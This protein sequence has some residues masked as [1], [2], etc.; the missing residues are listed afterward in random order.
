[1]PS[2]YLYRRVS[3]DRQLDKAGIEIQVTEA[4]IRKLQ[5]AHPTFNI[6]D[7][8][9]DEG[10]S[11]YSGDH[12]KEGGRLGAFIELCMQGKIEKGSILATY[13]LDRLSRLEKLGLT[14][15]KVYSPLINNSVWIYS[16]TESKY[17][18]DS[19]LDLLTAALIFSRAKDESITKSR[20]V[21]SAIF[22]GVDKWQKNKI[23][24][25]NLT[26]CAFWI[27]NNTGK[28]N[29]WAVAA[30]YIVD[31]LLKGVR[32]ITLFE[33]L[34]QKFPRF[35]KRKGSESRTFWSR[36]LISHLKYN[37]NLIG[38]KTI[39]IKNGESKGTYLLEK[40]YE[41]LVTHEEYQLLLSV[42]STKQQSEPIINLITSL[43]GIGTCTECGYTYQARKRKNNLGVTYYCSG[44][45]YNYAD[46]QS[47]ALNGE[48]L[49]RSIVL[50]ACIAIQSSIADKN[51][52]NGED[53]AHKELQQTKILESLTAL[54]KKY[55]ESLSATILELITD[56]EA[57]LKE[58]NNELEQLRSKAKVNSDDLFAFLTLYNTPDLWNNLKHPKRNELKHLLSTVL[59]KVNIT[60]LP[61]SWLIEVVTKDGTAVGY[62]T[63]DKYVSMKKSNTDDAKLRLLLS[64][65]YPELI[66]NDLWH[67]M[68]RKRNTSITTK[69][70]Q[71][72]EKDKRR[73]LQFN[74][75]FSHPDFLKANSEFIDN[76]KSK[77]DSLDIVIEKLKSLRKE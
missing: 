28:L 7:L 32:Y 69:Y 22:N 70:I 4:T 20:R 46:H 65:L 58:L 33:E 29:E 3:S 43:K 17:Y 8:G 73:I 34:N 77:V 21:N 5:T 16:E 15:E 66:Y 63:A 64:G 26:T 53:I 24:T 56:T 51:N 76:V 27:D 1:M 18:Q 39:T 37:E 25:P 38:D 74:N 40:Y 30:R 50:M 35:C 62:N 23:F 13:N 14:F 55:K 59:Q 49:E 71:Q 68:T 36:T 10:L 44:S 72:A 31:G 12:L 67:Y 60:A 6:V 61:L 9:N 11:A 42:K 57:D 41:P 54:K 75:Y 48:L 47:Y 2:I 52:N 19:D 45:L